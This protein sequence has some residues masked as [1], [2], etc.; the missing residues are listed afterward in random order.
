[1]AFVSVSFVSAYY[2]PFVCLCPRLRDANSTTPSPLIHSPR[3]IQ[4]TTPRATGWNSRVAPNVLNNA[5]GA[6]WSYPPKL[7]IVR[8][9]VLL[10]MIL[11]TASQ[12]PVAAILIRAFL[13]HG[14]VYSMVLYY[15]SISASL[16][17][18]ALVFRPLFTF[19]DLRS[20]VDI[21]EESTKIQH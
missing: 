10:M 15:L 1:M 20:A 5:S 2:P 4:A 13:D 17:M 21:L 8:R 3:A 18:Q 16:T 12:C 9:S 14:S 6:K 19:L 7:R 11:V